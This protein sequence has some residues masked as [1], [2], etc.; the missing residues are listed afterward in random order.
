[1]QS[2]AAQAETPALGNDDGA[3][4]ILLGDHF[5]SGR[6]FEIGPGAS[7][8][9]YRGVEELSFIDKRNREE[10][11]ELFN[12]RIDYAVVTLEEAR[13]ICRQEGKRDFVVA[14]HV[15]EHSPDP[16]QTTIDWLALIRDGGRFFF[17]IPSHMNSCEKDRVPTP[18]EH[19][20]DDYLFERSGDDFESKGHILSFIDQWT[21]MDERSIWYAQNGVTA[22]AQTSLSEMRRNGHDLHWH[23]YTLPVARQVIEAAAYFGGRRLTWLLTENRA[24]GHYLIGTLELESGVNPPTFLI[25]HREHLLRALGRLGRGTSLERE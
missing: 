16:I 23:T 11:E 6:G 21:V 7:P 2:K 22:F 14:H 17:S 15:L 1:M 25:A 10:L 4:R 3:N 9:A 12:V 20:V 13:A 24:N 8:A 18:I 5:L 19:I